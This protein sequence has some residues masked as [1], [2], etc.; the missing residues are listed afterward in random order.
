MISLVREMTRLSTLVSKLSSFAFTVNGWVQSYGSRWVKHPI[1]YGDSFVINEQERHE[2]C[3]PIALAIMEEVEDLE[4]AGISVIQIDE[5]A[6]R[7]G[8]PLRNSEQPFYL[9][10]IH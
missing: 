4:R 6:L 2:T 7:E 3:Y 8:L 10:W 9:E 5:A 1:I